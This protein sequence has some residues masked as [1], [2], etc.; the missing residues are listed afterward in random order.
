MLFNYVRKGVS[1]SA[2]QRCIELRSDRTSERNNPVLLDYVYFAF[3]NH[4]EP[5][6]E[7]LTSY[8]NNKIEEYYQEAD[9][10]HDYIKELE[11]SYKVM[12][13]NHAILYPLYFFLCCKQRKKIISF[14]MACLIA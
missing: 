12:K 11:I 4:N 3:D 1:E 2:Q 9:L 6:I 14:Y 13:T 5:L 10:L 7:F 8:Y